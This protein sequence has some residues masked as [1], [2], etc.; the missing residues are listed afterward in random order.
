MHDKRILEWMEGRDPGW[1]GNTRQ[2]KE[3]VRNFIHTERG[4]KCEE[5]GWDER[6]PIDNKVLTEIDHID[7]NAENCHL[8]NLKILCPNCHS[9][10]PTFRARNKV[11]KR[12]R[13]QV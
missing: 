2:L 12:N 5:C 9:K 13:K 7:G 4:T 3:F 1:T 8:S 10:T 6:H 11:S